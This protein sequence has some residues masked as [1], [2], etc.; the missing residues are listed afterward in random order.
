MARRGELQEVQLDDDPA[1]AVA[2]GSRRVPVRRI[3]AGLLVLVVALAAT[4]W[5]LAA[6]ERAALAEL[7]RVPGVLSPMDEEL[8]VER[9][10]PARESG[11]L[12]GVAGGVLDRAD[13]GS[14]TYTWLGGTDGQGSWST[15]LMGPSPQLAE[16][17]PASVAGGSE[18]A[19]D[20][21]LGRAGGLPGLR[22]RG[23]RRVGCPGAVPARTS[24]VI[25]LSATDGSVLA[26]WPVDAGVSL[27][28]L[29][30]DLVALAY[31]TPDGTTVTGF[32]ALTGEQRWSQ[33]DPWA[34][35]AA[36]SQ[37]DL[38]VSLSRVGDVLAS[39]PWGG[40]VR[41]LS[42]DGDI[43]RDLPQGIGTR[44]DGKGWMGDGVGGISYQ[45]DT[46]DG[47]R[48]TLV[49]P[50]GDPAADV[51]VGGSLFHLALDDGSVP[52]LV[53]TV[54][55][56]LRAWDGSTGAARWS[57]G[58]VIAAS[59][60]L[61]MRGRVFVASSTGVVALDGATG[62]KLWTTP[63]GRGWSLGPTMFTD[64]RH[65]LVPVDTIP[66]GGTSQLVAYDPASGREVFRADYPADVGQLLKAERFLVGRD[67][68][69]DEYLVLG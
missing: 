36:H 35:G 50:D 22:R 45:T 68:A 63:A 66:T 17:D 62:D 14:Q 30:D 54:G 11:P 33:T 69:T 26:Q 15:Q 56:R 7:A 60:A 18:C 44:L 31:A 47:V 9:R 34:D 43:V 39:S 51:T 25:V 16:L 41:L 65:L 10:V 19:D 6:R 8:V 4:Q 59:S 46:A 24:Q 67:L 48:T 13:D 29:P 53:L 40:P 28:V 27:A 49:A 61:I 23:G 37:N 3:V 52:D 64:G 5:V 2:T 32:D 55:D 20:G 42:A 57:D 12:F 21:V 58:T 1:P 38:A